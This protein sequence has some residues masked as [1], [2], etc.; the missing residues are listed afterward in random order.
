MNNRRINDIFQIDSP[1]TLIGEVLEI[2]NVISPDADTN[3]IRNVFSAADKLY[4]G[5]FPGYRA[6][7]T[8]YHDLQHAYDALLATARLIHG[9]VIDGRFFSARNI[10]AGLTAALLHDAGYI[11]EAS[12]TRGTGAKYKAIHEQRSMEFLKRHGPGFGLSSRQI[13]DGLTI[14]ACTEMARDISTVS[15][16]SAEIE[17]LGRM[18]ATADLLSQLADRAYLE[19]LPLLYKECEEAGSNEYKDE[20]DLIRKAVTFYDVAA[21]RLQTVLA[22]ADRFIRQHF[23]QR[24]GVAEN[25]YQNVIDSQKDFL[26]SILNIPDSDP[27]EHLK[28]W[29]THENP[30]KI[31][32]R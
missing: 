21:Q 5:Q 2:L 8:G 24:L 30:L 16:A 20:L 14:I 17:L 22:S 6:C 32:D 4:R 7:N 25:V 23:Q 13:D 9:S 31:S 11:Q 19:K 12:D 15:F 29:R 3:S 28:R 27:R 1:E 10:V 18:L 26:I